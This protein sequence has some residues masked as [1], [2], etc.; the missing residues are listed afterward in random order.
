MTPDTAEFPRDAQWPLASPWT[1]DE[2][3]IIEAVSQP[4]VSQTPSEPY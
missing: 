4:N 1:D 2:N 3:G